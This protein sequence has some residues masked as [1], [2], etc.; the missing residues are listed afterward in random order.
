MDRA[1]FEAASRSSRIDGLPGIYRPLARQFVFIAAS[2]DEGA[3]DAGSDPFCM[4]EQF[5]PRFHGA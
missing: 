2:K 5:S 1:L 3:K 4:E